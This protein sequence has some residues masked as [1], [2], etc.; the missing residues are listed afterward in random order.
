MLPLSERLRSSHQIRQVFAQGQT[1]VEP[2]MVLRVLRVNAGDPVRGVCF[3][4]GKKIGNAVVRNRLRRQL[5][6]VYRGLLDRL[7]IGFHVVFV[8]RSRASGVQQAVLE[9]SMIRLLLRAGL[10]TEVSN[11]G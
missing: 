8:V 7:P 10:M 6:S 2:L 4:V 1:F 9:A 3:T 5:R 11:K